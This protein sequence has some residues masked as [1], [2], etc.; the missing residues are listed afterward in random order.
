MVLAVL[1]AACAGGDPVAVTPST[2][3]PP[4]T[5][6]PGTSLPAASESNA[7]PDTTG[8]GVES[9]NLAVIGC[10]Q[11]RD[12]VRGYNDVTGSGRFPDT[13]DVLYLS[14]GTVDRWAD[15]TTYYW[16]DFAARLDPDADGLWIMLCWH[17]RRTDDATP[18]A[19]VGD[20]IDGAFEL[21][22]R[23]VPV[24]ISGLNDWTDRTTCRKADYPASWGLAEA[25]VEAGLGTLGPNLG[26][27]AEN[28]TTDGCHGNE[29]GNALMGRQLVEYFGE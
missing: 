14:G 12:A 24:Y 27:L 4:S 22:G 19:V 9:E 20:I 6:E 7:A 5:G 17:E 3:R 13:S 10:S 21:L 26:P 29:E 28:Q 8:P 15:P 16:D 11:T 25:S 23:Q 2:A 18:P 1:A